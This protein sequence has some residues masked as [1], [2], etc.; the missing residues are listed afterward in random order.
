[1]IGT[2]NAAL[3]R[4]CT[5]LAEISCGLLSPD[6]SATTPREAAAKSDRLYGIPETIFSGRAATISMRP[7]ESNGRNSAACGRPVPRRASS[8]S[9]PASSCSVRAA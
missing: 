4:I 1:M 7:L 5:M 6:N 2:H 8:S 3:I 9:T